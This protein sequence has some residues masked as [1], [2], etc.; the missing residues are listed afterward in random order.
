MEERKLTEKESLEVI[1][2]MIARTK[3]HYLGSGNNLLMWG[4]LVVA[5]SIIVW[6]LLAATHQGYWNWLWFAIPLIGWPTQ[7][8][9]GRK[10]ERKNGAVSYSDKITSRMWIIVGASEIVLTLA[11]IALKVFGSINCWGSMLVYSLLIVPAAEITQGLIVKEN[12]LTAGGA[13]GLTIGQA[14][15]CCVIGGVALSTSWYM[16]MFILAF[17]AMMIIPGHIINKKAKHK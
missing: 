1:T 16:S 17:V 13:I 14:T 2:S 11:C 3:A 4:Y 8:I 5:V 12:S 6:M 10:T 7:I 15:L 9:M